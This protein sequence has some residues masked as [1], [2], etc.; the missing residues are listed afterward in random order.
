MTHS[1]RP[2]WRNGFSSLMLFLN[3]SFPKVR[4]MLFLRLLRCRYLSHRHKGKHRNN[5][6]TACSCERIEAP[7]PPLL[8]RPTCERLELTFSCDAILSGFEDLVSPGSDQF[9]MRGTITPDEM[10]SEHLVDIHRTEADFRDAFERIQSSSSQSY[11][12]NK[13]FSSQSPVQ[14]RLSI[15]NWNHGPQ[16]GKAD[17][18][19]KQLQ[20]SGI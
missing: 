11:G 16:R 5:Q 3:V 20:E 15:Y 19:E 10:L 12:V 4:V 8:P 2:I 6:H 13:Y 18:I 1:R 9:T 7:V 17:A 14:T